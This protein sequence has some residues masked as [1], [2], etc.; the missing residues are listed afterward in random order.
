MQPEMKQCSVSRLFDIG[1]ASHVL[2]QLG[3]SIVHFVIFTS[4]E[5]GKIIILFFVFTF[6]LKYYFTN[7][8]VQ[9]ICVHKTLDNNHFAWLLKALNK[10]ICNQSSTVLW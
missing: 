6:F 1:S 5:E 8:I 2:A 7:P 4:S 9:Q 3:Y 10:A